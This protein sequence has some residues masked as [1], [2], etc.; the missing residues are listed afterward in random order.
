MPTRPPDTASSPGYDPEIPVTRAQELLSRLRARA[1]RRR[2]AWNIH[3]SGFVAVNAFLAFLD[4]VTGGILWF[5]YVTGAMLIPLVSHLIHRRR[6]DRLQTRLQ[7]ELDRNPDLPNRIFRPWRKA[8]RSTSHF[9]MGAAAAATISGYLFLINIMVGGSFWSIIPAA[10]LAL[11][12]VFHGLMLQGRKRRLNRMIEAGGDGKPEESPRRAYRRV[13]R[14]VDAAPGTA[15][16]TANPQVARAGYDSAATV[17]EAHELQRRI[18]EQLDLTDPKQVEI[19]AGV[20]DLVSEIE[21]LCTLL[22]EFGSALGSISL[23]EL[24]QDR[25]MLAARAMEPGSDELERQYREALA[26]VERQIEGYHGLERRHELMQV[27]L[28]TSINSLRQINVDLVRMKGDAALTDINQLVQSS[29]EEL[30]GYLDDLSQ[31][32]SEL[33]QELGG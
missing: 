16:R 19:L 22:S 30:S 23:A 7:D 31:S 5:P 14:Q 8:F 26:Q 10:S 21:R 20:D 28:R 24:E 2:A 4:L 15:G 3:V 12:A 13:G 25:E 6:R 33:R 32:Y 1:E 17:S 29:A 9:L 18:G 27:R 11:P